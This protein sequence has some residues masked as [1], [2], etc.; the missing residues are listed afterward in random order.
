MQLHMSLWW[1]E[2]LSALS[3][4]ALGASP[5]C[6]CQNMKMENKKERFYHGFV[7][8]V[9]FALFF[10]A[11]TDQWVIR[12]CGFLLFPSECCSWSKMCVCLIPCFKI[13]LCFK[14]G[15]KTLFHCILW[16]VFPEWGGVLLWQVLRPTF[17]ILQ[18][19][20]RWNTTANYSKSKLSWGNG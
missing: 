4:I 2:R 9:D 10:S 7:F 14:A 8:L 1:K 19:R 12:Y 13:N 20:S 3:W 11:C 18:E 6:N 17:Q 16:N 15:N 5:P